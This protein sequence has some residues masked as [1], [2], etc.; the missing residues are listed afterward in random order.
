MMVRRV[1]LL[2]RISVERITISLAVKMIR[3]R[4]D[5]Y[6]CSKAFA[7]EKEPISPHTGRPARTIS[8]AAIAESIESIQT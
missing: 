2:K 4:G 7:G 5:R 6:L 1:T 3:E 8:A